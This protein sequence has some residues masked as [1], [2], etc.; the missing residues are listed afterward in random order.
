MDIK[1]EDDLIIRCFNASGPVLVYLALAL[2]IT[3]VVAQ[4]GI[5]A[6]WW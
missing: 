3:T 1:T 4:I 6:G 2:F 5:K